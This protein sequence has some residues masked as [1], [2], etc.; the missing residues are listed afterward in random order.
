MARSLEKPPNKLLL[1]VKKTPTPWKSSFSQSRREELVLIRLR[2]G[3]SRITH[4]HLLNPDSPS[5]ASC[6]HC[7]QQNLTV[8]HIFACPLLSPLRTSLNLPS[9]IS[10][11][12]KNNSNTVSPSPSNTCGSPSSTPPSDLYKFMIYFLLFLD[13][14]QPYNVI[15]RSKTVE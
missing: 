14:Q 7:M 3:H 13:V 8:E 6:P 9:S 11:A 4:S 10:Q 1:C 2:I 5:P 12:P 15:I